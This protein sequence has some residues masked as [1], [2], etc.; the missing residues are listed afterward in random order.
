MDR[1]LELA[2]KS[3]ILHQDQAQS[4]WSELMDI[5]NFENLGHSAQRILPRIFKNLEDSAEIPFYEKLKGAYKYNW[6]K[7]NRLLVPFLPIIL[8]MNSKE[9]QYRLLKGAAL[10]LMSKSPGERVMGD[11]D[12]LIETRDLN[13]LIRI[14]EFQGYV[15]K[16]DTKCPNALSEI[17]E[18]EIC[19]ISPKN[20]EVD[21]HLAEK[22][23]PKL[24]FQKMMQT[25][26]LIENFHNVQV[27]LPSRELLLLH[28]AFHG[29]QAV[30][31][32]DLTQTYV[33]IS[34]LM[35]GINFKELESITNKL[36]I[37]EILN[38]LLNTL[39]NLTNQ[40]LKVRKKN[41]INIWNTNYLKW[42]IYHKMPIISD[43]KQIMQTRRI[44]QKEIKIIQKKFVGRKYLYLIWVKFGKPRPLESVFNRVLGG[45]LP[46]P[47][48]FMRSGETKLV[49]D[50]IQATWITANNAS[51]E[52]H[53]WRFKVKHP[54]NSSIT[55][56][57]LSAEGFK[58]WNWLVFVN[59]KLQGTTMQN[60][61]GSYGISI[62]DHLK[63]FEISLRSPSHV[64]QLC[65]HGLSDLALRVIS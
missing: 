53:D 28:S 29:H 7:N 4:A 21:I 31:E 64:C 44:H 10:N 1:E 5:V 8:E 33:D 3:A 17:I 14:L 6:V 52:A 45:F 60:P 47:S 57:E 18:H 49:F 35:V 34:Q 48:D 24:L 43:F 54:K 20:F 59:G 63:Y 27:Y 62:S 2:I 9:I 19:Y 55:A 39:N 38:K 25:K 51:R 16:Y 46:L 50:S 41:R 56:I 42:I 26:P 30:A 22:S 13:E 37:Y 32:T 11:I 40:N 65:E 12:L 61:N 15:K 36:G 58:H 23:Y